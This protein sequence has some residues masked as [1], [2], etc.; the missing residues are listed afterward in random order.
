M[1]LLIV[2]PTYKRLTKLF[3]CTRSIVA[4]KGDFEKLVVIVADNNDME[5]FNYFLKHETKNYDCLLQNEQGFV[6]GA[7]NRVAHDYQLEDWDAMLWLC[8]DVELLP[9]AI[10]NAIKIMENDYPD[11]DGIVGFKQKCPGHPD[12]T[13]K[14]FG[15]VM[16]G[17]KF[18]E[19]Y[20]DVNYQICCPDYFHFVQDRELF[21]YA[22]SMGKFTKSP[23]SVL[24]HYHPAFI[25]EEMDA[26][27]D[28]VRSGVNSPKEKDFIMEKIRKQKGYNWGNDWNLINGENK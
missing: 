7:W 17:R 22:N 13:F 1:K 2:I 8:D 24:Y 10:N 3:R 28:E 4:S 21:D 9:D 14:W 16:I 20:K 6:I 25:S 26:T 19:R 12:Y 23:N 27:H 11:Y 15:Q 5:T 18:I